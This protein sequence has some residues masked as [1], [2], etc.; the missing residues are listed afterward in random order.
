MKKILTG[1]FL[2][3]FACSC[4]K[5]LYSTQDVLG[6][7]RSKDQVIARYGLPTVK[8]EE[9]EYTEFYY[10]HGAITLAN[11]YSRANVDA[12]V[13]RTRDGAYGSATGTGY[14]IG[15][16]TS[17]NRYVKYTFDKYDRV[18]GA[19]SRGVDLAEKKNAPGKTILAILLTVGA[20]AGLA[21][22]LESGGP[23]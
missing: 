13:T 22:A 14:S 3:I 18:I 2:A 19:E 20:G 5:T 1:L 17:F 4:T 9:G 8:R 6:R 16:A 21:F 10:D 12:S 15:S 11:S 23:Y 7:Y